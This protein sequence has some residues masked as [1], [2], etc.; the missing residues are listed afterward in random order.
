MVVLQVTDTLWQG[1][2]PGTS[3]SFIRA[4]VGLGPC[5]QGGSDGEEMRL[6]KAFK[7]GR[8]WRGLLQPHKCMKTML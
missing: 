4:L 5:L 1:I 7:K 3:V 8:V 2:N 6:A